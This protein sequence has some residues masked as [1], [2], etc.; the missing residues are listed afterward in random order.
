[1][2]V[3]LSPYRWVVLVLN[4]VQ[5][6]GIFVVAFFLISTCYELRHL[7]RGRD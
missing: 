3:A 4:F 2:V 6:V 1:M 5:T 7:R